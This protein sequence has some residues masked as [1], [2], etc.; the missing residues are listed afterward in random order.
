MPADPPL[1]A[2]GLD[3][4]PVADGLVIYDPHTDR[5][6]YLNNTAAAIFTLC[7]GDRRADAIA[8]AVATLFGADAPSREEV[9]ACLAQLAEEGVLRSGT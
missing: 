4:N 5:V 2:D 3:V 6:H 9:D 1:A 8:G 7:D